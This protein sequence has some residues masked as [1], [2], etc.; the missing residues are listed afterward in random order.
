MCLFQ[1]FGIMPLFTTTSF[2]PSWKH[3]AFMDRMGILLDVCSA[4]I[5]TREPGFET[6]S[7]IS[8]YNLVN[9]SI[10]GKQA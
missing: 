3:A 1:I 8:R 10:A 6:M 4:A 2:T 7:S 9:L 5:F